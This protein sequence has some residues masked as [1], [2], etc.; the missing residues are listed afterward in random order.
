[1]LNKDGGDPAPR[2]HPLRGRRGQKRWKLL[3][4]TASGR[5]LAVV[6][7]VRRNLF[8]AVTAYEMNRAEK[9]RYAPQ[10]D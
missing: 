9:T 3:G 10:I 4:K 8:R 1:M 2:S 5:Y 6:F 7:T